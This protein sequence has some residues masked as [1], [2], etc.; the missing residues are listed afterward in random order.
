MRRRKLP[1]AKR[2]R[3]YSGATPPR[4]GIRVVWAAYRVPRGSPHERLHIPKDTTL[5]LLSDRR[6][7]VHGC[8]PR[9]VPSHHGQQLLSRRTSVPQREIFSNRTP[10]MAARMSEVVFLHAPPLASSARVNA[11]SSARRFL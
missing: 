2:Q 9:I 3:L 4:W 7:R 8:D 11:A 10:Q 5:N 1:R 6:N